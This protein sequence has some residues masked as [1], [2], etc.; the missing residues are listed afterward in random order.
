M[1]PERHR[2][3]YFLTFRVK[4][5]ATM[6]GAW[7]VYN[8]TLSPCLYVVLTQIVNVVKEMLAGRKVKDKTLTL[9][10]DLEQV[11]R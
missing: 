9:G 2:V 10:T 1:S 8:N 11:L 5:V 7:P 4:C 3:L 6:Q